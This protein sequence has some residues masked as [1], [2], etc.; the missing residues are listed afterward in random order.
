[1]TIAPSVKSVCPKTIARAS[2][3]ETVCLIAQDLCETANQSQFP[4]EPAGVF[5][6]SE[7]FEKTVKREEGEK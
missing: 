3:Q 1:V 2:I 7:L 5:W 4:A 6:N